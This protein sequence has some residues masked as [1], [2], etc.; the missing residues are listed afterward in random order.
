[1]I[2][3]DFNFIN[4]EKDKGLNPTDKLTTGLAPFSRT[5]SKEEDLVIYWKTVMKITVGFTTP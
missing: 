2:L 3:D 1:M 5:E 4:H